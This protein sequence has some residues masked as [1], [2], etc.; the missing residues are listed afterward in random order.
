MTPLAGYRILV[1]EDDVLLAMDLEEILESWGAKVLGPVPRVDRALD[2][3]SQE[4]PDAATIDIK[5]AGALSIPVATELKSRN[6]PFIIVSAYSDVAAI[7]V[8]LKQAPYLRK[9]YDDQDLLNAL[10]A[11][12]A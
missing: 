9:P 3:L 12:L 1:I 10:S 11:I 8:V 5:L 6:I 4:R 7:D 2:L